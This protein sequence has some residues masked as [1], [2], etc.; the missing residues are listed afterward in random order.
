MPQ[1]DGPS[2]EISSP[3]SSE[4][5]KSDTAVTSLNF[6]VRCSSLTRMRVALFNVC[7]CS[8]EE[9]RQ[10]PAV[11]IGHGKANRYT[12][13]GRFVDDAGAVDGRPGFDGGAGAEEGRAV[14]EGGKAAVGGHGRLVIAG[15]GVHEQRVGGDEVEG[16]R[17]V[18]LDDE[19]EGA[20]EMVLRAG[21]LL[22][23]DVF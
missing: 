17:R 19:G 18:A 4:A 14:V 16:H 7:R 9:F 22:G 23:K 11:H 20:V 13:S 12:Y 6:L 3:C 2:R 5:E 1:P 8:D 10:R 21:F 15:M